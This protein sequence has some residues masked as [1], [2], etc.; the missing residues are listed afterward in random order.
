M[1][2]SGEKNNT[3]IKLYNEN[4]TRPL[5]F[6]NKIKALKIKN[7]FPRE[8]DGRKHEFSRKLILREISSGFSNVE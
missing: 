1:S 2:N 6:Q 7:I 5:F 4:Y 8:F 3:N